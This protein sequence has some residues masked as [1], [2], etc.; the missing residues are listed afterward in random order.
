MTDIEQYKSLIGEVIQKQIV[1]LGPG[2]AVLKAK[3]VNGLSVTDEGK[4][5]DIQ[6]DPEAVLKELIDVYVALA[7]Q[8]VKSAL[9]SIFDKYSSIKRVV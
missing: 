8:I 3:N 5:V 2:I 6:G 1:I 9:G 4:V 7:G